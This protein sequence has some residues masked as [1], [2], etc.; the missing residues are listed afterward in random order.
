MDKAL[1]SHAGGLGS[2]PDN[3]KEDFSVWKKFK[4]ELLSPREPY[5]V[6]SPNG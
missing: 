4:Y 6:L 1:A 2:N 5:H 3:T